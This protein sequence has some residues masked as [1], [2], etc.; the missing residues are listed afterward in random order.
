[1]G[2]LSIF[3]TGIGLAMDAFAVSVAKGITLSK[4]RI[5]DALKVAF[6]FGGFQAIMPLIGW[7]AG[8]YFADYIKAF[9]HWIAFILLSFIG[10]KM[11]LEA[12]KERREEGDISIETNEII[13]EELAIKRDKEELSAKSLTILAIA[14]SIDALAVGVSFAFLGISIFKSI[15][16]IGIITFVLCFIGVLIG[17]KLG[18][19]FKNYA[20]IIG[21]IIL[22]L[23]GLNILLEHTGLIEKF[24]F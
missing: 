18:D 15:I 10:G 6:F 5:K 19:I 21:G 9:D 2:F 8:I 24:F 12:I 16:I 20:E 17:E 1:M 13:K 11:L 3:L 23:I 14:T 22:I 4:I 7:G